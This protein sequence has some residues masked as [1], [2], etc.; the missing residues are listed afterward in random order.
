MNRRPDSPE[1]ALCTFGEKSRQGYAVV[2]LLHQGGIDRS[3]AV[4]I[5]HDNRIVLVGCSRK[6]YRNRIVIRFNV[7]VLREFEL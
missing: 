3:V 1:A 5:E 6:C 4:R 7:I 2:R